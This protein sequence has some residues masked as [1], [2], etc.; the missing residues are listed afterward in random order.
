M[1]HYRN[2]KNG[3]HVGGHVRNMFLDAVDAYL[4]WE[5]GEPEPTVDFEVRFVARPITISRACGIVWNCSDIL[6]SGAVDSCESCG[7][8]LGRR[9]YAPAARALLAAIKDQVAGPT[10]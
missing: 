3:G 6:P 4:A 5:E 7:I 2:G 10:P 1:S 9:T 8:E